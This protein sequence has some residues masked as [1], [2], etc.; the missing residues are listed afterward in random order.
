MKVRNF[1]GH[2]VIVEFFF[3]KLS[4]KNFTFLDEQFEAFW[5]QSLVSFIATQRAST[6]RFARYGQ[7]KQIMKFQHWLCV[8]LNIL[9][10]VC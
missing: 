10:I 1:L 7:T 9:G 5:N 2:S 6:S 8:Y 3:Q 4:P